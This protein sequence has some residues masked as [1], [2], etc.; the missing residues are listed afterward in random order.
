MTMGWFCRNLAS[1]MVLAQC[2]SMRSESVSRPM[3]KL[4]DPK[5]LW[6]M[7]V[8]QTLHAA[9]HDER[10][11]HPEHALGAEG[12]PRSASRGIPATAP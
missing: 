11:V 4:N 7:P 12:V 8:A 1:A 6:H 3:M 10:D 9:P 5:G 2:R